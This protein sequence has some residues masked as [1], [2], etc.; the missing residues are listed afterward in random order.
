MK[1]LNQYINEGLFNRKLSGFP[2]TMPAKLKAIWDKFYDESKDSIKT[3]ED[4]MS[5]FKLGVDEFWEEFRNEFDKTS[6]L[7]KSQGTIDDDLKTEIF[8]L[9]KNTL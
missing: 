1:T 2:K 4:L 9:W 6:V 7:K 8:N 3:E 5:F